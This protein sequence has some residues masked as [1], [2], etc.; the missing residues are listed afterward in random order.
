MPKLNHKLK[1]ADISP[2]LEEIK[3]KEGSSTQERSSEIPSTEH[4]QSNS[5]MSKLNLGE[6]MKETN[7]SLTEP[8]KSNEDLQMMSE[9]SQDG[10]GPIRIV[11]NNITILIK[12]PKE[13]TIIGI[14]PETNEV[15]VSYKRHE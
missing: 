10:D 6:A 8:P 12:N 13:N 4:L 1:P 3:Q 2:Y 5:N 15:K 9:P 14:D 7:K 11:V